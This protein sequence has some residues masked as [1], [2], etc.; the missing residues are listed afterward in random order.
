MATSESSSPLLELRLRDLR[1]TEAPV[2]ITARIVSIARRQV[3]RKSDGESRQVLS[4]LLS[5]GT[6]TVR[7]TWWDPPAEEID[8]GTV[9]R[10]APVQIREFR[11][12]PELSF[13]WRTR[14]APASE[15][16]LP[17]LR[18]EDLPT[19]RLAD[20]VAQEEGFRVE[21]RVVEVDSKRVS[22]GTERRE[23]FQ[24]LLADGSGIAAFSAWSDFR[25]RAGEAIRLT[26]A[27]VRLFRGRPQLVLDERTHLERIGGEGL[28]TLEEAL[29]TE[30]VALG[31]LLDR[32]GAERAVFEGRALA[33][34]PPSGLLPKCPSC[35]RLVREGRCAT[36]GP[37]NGVPDLRLRLVVDDGSGAATV[38]LDGA[39]V[40]RLTGL[41]I[42]EASRRLAARGD[43]SDVQAA[44]LAPVFGRRLRVRGPVRKDDFGLSVY[45]TEVALLPEAPVGSDDALR[46]RLEGA[47]R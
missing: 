35:A 24:G 18:T 28:P 44:L 19:R 45:P 22:V 16:E 1:V 27:Y 34:Q 38:N 41:T 3:A 4:G 32:G 10:A 39:A 14:V 21:A 13:G 5:D 31:L 20:L 30:P 33:V 15:A 40:E 26:G 43:P 11:G 42:A 9:I 29:R 23:V 12:K 37:V 8:R 2:A 47:P 6:A 17:D 7:F 36:H 25:L 46:R